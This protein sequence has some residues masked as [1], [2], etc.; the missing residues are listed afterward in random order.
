M[1]LTPRQYANLETIRTGNYDVFVGIDPDIDK[2]GVAIK[3]KG[4][5]TIEGKSLDLNGIITLCQ[6]L[7]E[8][9]KKVLVI[10]EAS[11]LVSKS[12]YHKHKGRN[13]KS[14]GETIGRYVGQN[15]GIG[16]AIV[17]LLGSNKID[18][19]EAE[20]LRKHRMKVNGKWTKEGRA[21]FK[22]YLDGINTGEL[23]DDIRDAI[24]L[25]FTLI[26]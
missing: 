1:N 4:E 26:Q 21:T 17:Q 5:K 10:V 8:E 20:P 7:K 6:T 13:A 16:M 11:W 22:L 19:I 3:Y 12:N 9:G 25:I 14:V 24:W 18:F 23:N 15:Q 2:S